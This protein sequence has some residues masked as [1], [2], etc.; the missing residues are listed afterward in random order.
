MSNRQGLYPCASGR[1]RDVWRTYKRPTTNIRSRDV[2]GKSRVTARYTGEFRLG[3]T[4]RLID[5][6]TIRTGARRV[7]RVNRKDFYT[8]PLGL[9]LDKETELVKRPAMECSSLQLR[10]WLQFINILSFLSNA[11]GRNY[12]WNTWGLS[13]PTALAGGISPP[14]LVFVESVLRV[15]QCSGLRGHLLLFVGNKRNT[16]AT[17]RLRGAMKTGECFGT[18][19]QCL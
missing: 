3:R 17:S 4:I 6:T 13:L 8:M 12:A 5:T 11:G 10:T 2:I 14:N 19:S 15:G 18:A 9:V 7:L 1:S 16:R